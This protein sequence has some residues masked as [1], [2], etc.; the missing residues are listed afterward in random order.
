MSVS[1]SLLATAS[2]VV[3]F[4]QVAD[5]RGLDIET[6]ADLPPA[7]YKGRQYVDS[8]GCVFIRAGYG[9]SV[10]WVPRVT[11]GRDHLCGYK[12]TQ[13][14]GG[15][16]AIDVEEPKVVAPVQGKVAAPAQGKVVAPAPVEVASEPEAKSPI[17]LRSPMQTTA[18]LKPAAL[19]P[20]EPILRP[21]PQQMAQY[22]VKPVAPRVAVPAPVYAV[23][24]PVYA[25]PAPLAGGMTGGTSYG[26]YQSPYA[27]GASVA[28]QMPVVRMKA[29]PQAPVAAK[30]AAQSYS[31][32]S[33]ATQS[34]AAPAYS[35]SYTMVGGSGYAPVAHG[36]YAAPAY[37]VVSIASVE[38]L[39]RYSGCK[40]AQ[41]G[42]Q[43][44]TLSDGRQVVRC[45]PAAADPVA[46]LN[47]AGVAGLNVAP[48]QTALTQAATA[49]VAPSYVAPSYVAQTAP[50]DAKGR[51]VSGVTGAGLGS[52]SLAAAQAQVA[53]VGA[54]ADD[55]SM[56]A[57]LKRRSAA[58][59]A[60]AVAAPVLQ[61][62]PSVTTMQGGLGQGGS[63]YAA[64]FVQQGGALTV[65]P[66]SITPSL[67]P[68]RANYV[69]P[70][71][72]SPAGYKPAFRD[73]RLNPH[74]GPR[75]Y[76]GNAQMARVWS[77]TTPAQM[78]IF[79]D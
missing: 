36:S 66:S 33:S 34:Y 24:A 14:E 7:S 26:S 41:N 61:A 52:F 76:A 37:G 77:E 16:L 9:S 38:T 8:N 20:A 39:A 47:A 53:S 18:A 19:K 10:N 25:A 13:I 78:I 79:Q 42:A 15:K 56:E 57:L 21:K 45:G 27:T 28:P 40:R 30:V 6:A 65:A 4:A 2:L 75:T 22:Q 17:T 3:A 49:Y 48:A 60:R 71:A 63:G 23:P 32:Q 51:Y 62:Y 5:A 43:K 73:G 70:Y 35:T 44:Y 11:R 68:A 67:A 50:Y 58:K 12:P 55:P 1:K 74:R 31:G 72:A 64:S 59:Q 54:A 29:Q 46:A 69:S